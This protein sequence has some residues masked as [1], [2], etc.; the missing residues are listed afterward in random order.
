MLAKNLLVLERGR[1][2][3]AEAI[4]ERREVTTGS[5]TV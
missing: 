5:R 1:Q 2:L 4:G 3:L